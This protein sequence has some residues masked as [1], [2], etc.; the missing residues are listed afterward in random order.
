TAVA[1][2]GGR[3]AV[4]GARDGNA[5]NPPREAFI[6]EDGGVRPLLAV[7]EVTAEGLYV[8]WVNE[9][10]AIGDSGVT[11]VHALLTA[12]PDAT[13][14]AARSSAI[15]AVDTAGA[16]VVAGSGEAIAVERRFNGTWV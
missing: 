7:G 5:Y 1:S 2:P 11:A 4:R 10:V 3:I 9:V 6:V 8:D 15:L 16:R 12:T 13:D 14:P